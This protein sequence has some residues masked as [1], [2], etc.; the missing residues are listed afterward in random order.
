MR[1]AL[2]AIAAAIIALAAAGPADGAVILR[3]L[4]GGVA[5]SGD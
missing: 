2:P 5:S 1:P 4:V 3:P